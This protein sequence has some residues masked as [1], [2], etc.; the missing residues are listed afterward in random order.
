MARKTYEWDKIKAEFELGKSNAYIHKKYGVAYNTLSMKIKRD[1][2]E[3]VNNEVSVIREF[4]KGCE[5]VSEVVANNVNN[6]SKLEIIKEE[7][8]TIIEDNE[9]IGN[10]RKLLKAFQGLVGKGIKAGIFETPQDIKAGVSAIKDIEAVA[11]PTTAGIRV[12]N[13]INNQ[14]NQQ[15]NIQEIGVTFLDENENT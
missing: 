6:T 5:Q 12:E 15:T 1:G 8:N 11:N 7:L 9:L 13:N 2:W 10:N 4:K 3:V 14:N